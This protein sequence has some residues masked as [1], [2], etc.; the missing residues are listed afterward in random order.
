M[1]IEFKSFPTN[2]HGLQSIYGAK[3]YGLPKLPLPGGPNWYGPI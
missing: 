2:T 1:K 3:S